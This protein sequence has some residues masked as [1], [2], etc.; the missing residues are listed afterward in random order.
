MYK[1]TSTRLYSAK[2]SGNFKFINKTPIS[3]GY[4]PIKNDPKEARFEYLLKDIDSGKQFRFN[5][6]DSIRFKRNKMIES[7][8]S[9]YDN[10]NYSLVES[11]FLDSDDLPLNRVIQSIKQKSVNTNFPVLGYIWVIDVGANN[12]MHFHLVIAYPKLEVK[13][14]AI[15][16]FLKYSFRKNK[17]Y[18][19]FISNTNGFKTY[20]KKKKVFERGKR[21]R[22]YNKSIK[23]KTIT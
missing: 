21:K 1:N 8:F 15:P 4:K 16:K 13:N 6:V 10:P 19:R 7:F 14:A 5:D 18:S 23:L 9:V 17:I 3:D 20:L 2:T 11:C 12:K 22:T